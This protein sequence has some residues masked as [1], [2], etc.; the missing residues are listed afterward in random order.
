MDVSTAVQRAFRRRMCEI[1]TAPFIPGVLMAALT[2]AAAPPT[3]RIEVEE[4]RQGGR[5]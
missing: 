2:R 1:A 3:V 5:R 4:G